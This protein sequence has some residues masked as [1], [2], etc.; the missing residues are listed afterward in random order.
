M[1]LLFYLTRFTVAIIFDETYVHVCVTNSIFILQH[2]FYSTHSRTVNPMSKSYECV[3]KYYIQI[4][5]FDRD[6]LN[7]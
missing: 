7:N 5:L 6:L 1:T 4:F 2:S 3:A